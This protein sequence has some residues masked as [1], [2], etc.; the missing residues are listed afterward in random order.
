MRPMCCDVRSPMCC[1]VL[2]PFSDLY[3]PSP[4]DELR[5][6]LDSP[7][8]TQMISG[9][10]AAM[11]MSPIDDVPSR[12]NIGSHVVPAFVVFHTPPDAEAAYISFPIRPSALAAG[13]SS[14][15]RSTMRPLVT[16]GPMGRHANSES[17]AESYEAA[18]NAVV[19]ALRVVAASRSVAT[20]RSD[21]IAVE[22]GGFSS[23]KSTSRHRSPIH[24]LPLRRKKRKNCGSRGRL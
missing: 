16:A 14:T 5:W 22:L 19:C 8:P 11:A 6:L 18:L 4:Q 9:F 20:D 15:A 10:V 7:V 2:P 21:F 3:T 12:S 17:I 1:H 23:G 24:C 13:P